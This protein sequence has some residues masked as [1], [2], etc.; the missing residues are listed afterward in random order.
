MAVAVR[1]RSVNELQLL[2]CHKELVRVKDITMA[3]TARHNN[4]IHQLCTDHFRERERVGE[5]VG[6]GEI[7]EETQERKGCGWN[8]CPSPIVTP[9]G[10][11]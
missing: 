5:R 10:I 6:D 9:C 8:A 7:G 1:G 2:I 3:T 4:Y 11:Q